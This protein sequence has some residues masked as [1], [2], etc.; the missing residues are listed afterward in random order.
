MH[1]LNSGIVTKTSKDNLAEGFGLEKPIKVSLSQKWCLLPK[2][3]WKHKKDT[4]Y[5][6]HATRF[7]MPAK[8]PYTNLQDV[9]VVL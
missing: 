8:S 9:C 7:T 3:Q 5:V 6:A 1:K 2:L 4:W